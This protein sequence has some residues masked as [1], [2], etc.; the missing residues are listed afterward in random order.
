LE[1]R[2]GEKKRRIIGE[3]IRY[4]IR[5][6][7]GLPTFPGPDGELK[8]ARDR[9]FFLGERKGSLLDEKGEDFLE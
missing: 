5:P 2:G 1:S 6:M 3:K 8:T 7:Q 9:R 4:E